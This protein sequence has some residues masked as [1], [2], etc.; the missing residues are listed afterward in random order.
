MIHYQFPEKE[1]RALDIA[2]NGRARFESSYYRQPRAYCL[3]GDGHA[4]ITNMF[5]MITCKNCLDKILKGGLKV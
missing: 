5:T 1:K 3:S 4:R 2:E